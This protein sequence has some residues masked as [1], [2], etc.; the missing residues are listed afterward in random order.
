MILSWNPTLSGPETGSG[1]LDAL[2]LMVDMLILETWE[3]K[4]SR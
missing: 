3:K 1:S 2:A 4:E